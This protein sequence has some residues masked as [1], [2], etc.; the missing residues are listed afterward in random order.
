MDAGGA[1]AA[2]AIGGDGGD[3]TP[4]AVG[5]RSRGTARGVSDDDPP[6]SRLHHH[7]QAPGG[8]LGAWSGVEW[9]VG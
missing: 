2:L 3:L 6:R 8:V 9:R 1:R 4:H 5:G 7:D